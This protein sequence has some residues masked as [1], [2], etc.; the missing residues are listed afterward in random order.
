[1]QSFMIMNIVPDEENPGNYRW[2][3]NL[4]AI[5]ATYRENLSVEI[6][7]ANWKGSAHIIC[8]TRSHYVNEKKIAEFSTIFPNLDEKKDVHFINGAG[9]WVHADRPVEFT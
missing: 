5:Q 6:K 8:G 1:M 3:M 9:H 7:D 4:P 2:R